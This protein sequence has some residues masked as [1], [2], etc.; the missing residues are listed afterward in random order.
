VGFLGDG[1]ND[2]PA[3]READVGVSVDTAVDIAE[4]LA[5]PRKWEVR[6][7]GRFMLFI[8]PISSLFDYTTF[9]LVWF[10]FHASAPERQPL[11]QSSWFVEGLLSQTLIIHMIRTAKLPF[12]QSRAALPLLLL[13]A[14]IMAVGIYIPFSPL[15]GYLG[16]SSL[17]T[18]YFFWLAVTL[19]AYSAL[20]QAIK[21]LYI[22][23]FKLWL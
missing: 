9:A 17:P 5:R 20:T 7:I 3:L 11:F 8:G 4:Y 19:L 22:R 21:V 1:I 16:M 2:A 15:A 10:V 14:T 13:T 12:I 18:V 23:K 6:D